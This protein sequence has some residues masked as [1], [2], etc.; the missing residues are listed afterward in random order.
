MLKSSE[1]LVSG[2]WEA[3]NRQGFGDMS[4]TGNKKR[5]KRLILTVVKRQGLF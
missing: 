4:R 5:N 3:R 2:K 1:S